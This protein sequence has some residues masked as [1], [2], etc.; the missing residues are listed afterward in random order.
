MT[1]FKFS[2]SAYLI[3]FV[4]KFHTKIEL[5]YNFGKILGS[6]Y[7]PGMIYSIK[8]TRIFVSALQSRVQ[9]LKDIHQPQLITLLV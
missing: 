5:N 8:S 3:L 2:N 7:D 9:T 1:N 6:L 4:S